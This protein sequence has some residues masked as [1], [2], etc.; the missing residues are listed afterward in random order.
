LF[1]NEEGTDD[2]VT[3]TSGTTRSSISTTDGLGVLAHAVI[4]SGTKGRDLVIKFKEW[5]IIEL[6]R[7][8]WIRLD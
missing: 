3:D 4:F 6:N 7:K 2:T 5:N 1:F 8:D